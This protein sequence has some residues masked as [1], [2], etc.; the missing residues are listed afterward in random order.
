MSRGQEDY[1][2]LRP[3]SYNKAHVILI[4]FAVNAPDSLENVPTKVHPLQHYI[5]LTLVQWFDEVNRLCPGTPIV[6]VGLKSD[7]RDDPE[8]IE[9]MRR[10]SL[11]FVESQTVYTLYL[12]PY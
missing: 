9:D 4:A 2:R 11:R 1:E 5:S 8:A 7:L 12:D 10:K 3:L 6:L